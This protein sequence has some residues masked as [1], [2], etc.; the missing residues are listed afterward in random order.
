MMNFKNRDI[1]F[2]ALMDP[3]EGRRHVKPVKEE[4]VGGWDHAYNISEDYVHPTTDEELGWWSSSY[5]SLDSDDA[6]ENWKNLMHEVSIR[7]CSLITRSLCRVTTEIVELP[8]YEGIPDLYEFLVEFEYKVLETQRL[9]EL[10]E[11]L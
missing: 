4:V 2:I 8:T 7:K 1:K 5:T 11:A 6:L 3:Y 9:L 10:D